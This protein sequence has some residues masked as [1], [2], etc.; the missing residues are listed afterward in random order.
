M[1]TNMT[2][3]GFISIIGRTNVGKSTLL[4]RLIGRKISITS[5][6]KQTTRNRIL[7]I[8]TE[9]GYQ[10]IYIDTPGCDSK[11]K[12]LNILMNSITRKS[13]SDVSIVIFMVGGTIWNSE[14]QRV[15]SWLQDKEIPV[16]LVINKIDIIYNKSLL[17]PHIKF[18][19]QQ[20][21]FRDI[22]PISAI[23]GF[24][25]DKLSQIIRNFLPLSE[26]IYAPEVFTDQPINFTLA[27]IIREKLI[28]VLGDEIPS[29]LKVKIEKFY[30]KQDEYCVI[31]ALIM[32]NR[33]SH[34]KIII[35]INGKKIKN[36]GIKARFD[37]EKIMKLKVY[38]KLWIKVKNECTQDEMVLPTRKILLSL[39]SN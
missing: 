30:V 4:N 12:L 39:E 21:N 29:S 14:D 37:I 18:L 10:S 17:L 26:H 36:I 38:L 25:V 7:G 9:G 23:T 2:Y 3:C 27:E 22:I 15:L 24:N 20:K 1:K 16:I 34:K 32:V 6:K 33:R 8:A 5:N 31:Y 28:R 11:K 13:I 19:N 35:G